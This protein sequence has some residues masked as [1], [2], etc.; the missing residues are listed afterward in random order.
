MTLENKDQISEGFG[1]DLHTIGTGSLGGK[2]QGLVN[3]NDVL[4]S[5]FPFEEFPNIQ[6]NIPSFTVLKTGIFDAFMAQNDLYEIAYSDASDD[7]IA[8]A[9]QQADFPFEALGEL[10]ALINSQRMPM[11]IRSSSLLEDTIYEPFAGVYETKM[12]PNNQFDPNARFRK[13]VEAIKFVYASTFFEAAKSYIKATHHD[14]REEKMAVIIQEEVGKKHGNR[15][16]PELSG[17]ARSYNFYPIG[18]AK[19][20]D[21]IVN[22]ALGLGKTIVDGG[23]SWRYSPAYPK[24]SPPNRSVEELM[25]FSQNKFWA[26]NMGEP[27]EYNPIAETE[28]MVQKNITAAEIDGTLSNLVSTYDAYSQRLTM[29]MGN[30]GPRVLTFAPLL[31]LGKIPLNNLVKHLLSVCENALGGPVEIEFAMSFDPNY[32]GF[33]QVRRMVVFDD[34][35]DLEA[36]ELK[37]KNVLVS[38]EDVLGN[39]LNKEIVDVIFIKPD[40]FETKHTRAMSLELEK[41]NRKMVE[42]SSP[43]LLV[44]FGRLGTTD[45][46]LG[47]PINFGDISGAKVVIEATREDFKVELS[48]GSHYFHNLTSLGIGYFTVSHSND[49]LIDWD[50]LEGQEVVEET[51]FFRHVRLHLPLTVVIDG[52]KGKGVIYK[53]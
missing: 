44:V 6:V 33:L 7:Q 25:K 43:Y 34:D 28:Y 20:E 35:V 49:S 23:I 5:E 24:V 39:G 21:G 48:Q 50:W 26:I 42:K 46:W 40:R 27:L 53:S 32:F 12:I 18:R 22:L 9:F 41:L 19:N 10:R 45:P 14:I 4:E 47:I 8:L 36:E 15:F 3:I 16:Y 52:R 37:G 51:E 17:V 29:G 31:V 1:L 38:S 30:P 11:A 2:A 13:L